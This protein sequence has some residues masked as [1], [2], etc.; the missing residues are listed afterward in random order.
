MRLQIAFHVGITV[1]LRNGG[2]HALQIGP[3]RLVIFGRTLLCG[4]PNCQPFQHQAHLKE[5]L[6]I[7]LLQLDDIAAVGLAHDQPLML[8]IHQRMRTACG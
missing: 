2:V 8:Q 7:F 1:V 4:L 6:D 5:V 3:E